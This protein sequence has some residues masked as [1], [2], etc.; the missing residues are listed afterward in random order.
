M[1]RPIDP[2]DR[3]S[4]CQLIEDTYCKD[5]NN[6][7]GVRCRACNFDDA[8]SA[9]DAVPTLDYAPVRHGKW[10]FVESMENDYETEIA[11]RCSLCGRFV[12]RYQGV[13][14]DNYCPNCGT[15]MDGKEDAHG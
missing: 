5:C 9:L 1:P 12:Y 8:M 4:V 10:L 14:Q 3:N 13:P 11:E 6:Y 7:N 2:V 15:L